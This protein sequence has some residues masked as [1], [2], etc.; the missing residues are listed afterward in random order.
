MSPA[1]QAATSPRASKRIV[2]GT[3]ITL[4]DLASDSFSSALIFFTAILFPDRHSLA[5]KIAQLAEINYPYGYS[6]HLVSEAIYLPDPDGNGIE[7]Y[8]DR[9]RSE[10]PRLNGQIRM[11]TD[12]L[13]LD[14]EHQPLDPNH[15]VERCLQARGAGIDRQDVRTVGRCH[16]SI[17]SR[18]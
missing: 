17:Y 2:V 11:A 15:V 12:P 1:F 18:S 16:T 13:D 3:V 9:P 5:V 6:D 10:W 7:I 8:R 4:I 14:R